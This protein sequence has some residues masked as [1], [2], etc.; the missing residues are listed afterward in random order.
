MLSLSLMM[1]LAAADKPVV[2]V[3]Y[4][5]ARTKDEELV[6]AGK[7][8]A[9]MLTTDLVA[10]EGVRVVERTRLEEV[11]K[12][13]DFQQ[14]KYV[15]KKTAVKIGSALGADYLVVGS[16]QS[17]G[18][19]IRVDAR[20][21]KAK[22]FEDVVSA[23]E[24]DSKDKIFD[25]EQRLANQLVAKI[26]DKLTA[27][28]NARR[29]AKVPDLATVV[30]YGKALDLSDKGQLDEAQAAMRAV[31]SKS[32][33][34][35]LARERQAELLKRFEEYQ[36]RKKDMI[37]GGAIELGKRI[38]A[39]LKDE[40]KFSSLTKEEQEHFLAMRVLKGKFLARVMKQFLSN[41]DSTRVAKKGEE[42]RAL[43]AMR[44]W[45][46]NQRRYMGEFDRSSRQ[47]ATV[48]NGVSY[49]ASMSARLNDDEER[50]V[51][52]SQFGDVNINDFGFENLARFVLE[53]RVDDGEYFYVN[54]VLSA[55]DSKID[56]TVRDEIDARIKDAI[57]RDAAGDKRA[58]NDAT[59]LMEFKAGN[60]VADGDVDR[61]VGA[62]Q[63]MLDSFPTDSRASWVEGR[64]KDLLEGRGNELNDLNRWTEALQ[65]CKDMDIRVG[66]QVLRRRMKQAGL[67]GI[68]DL[69]AELEKK[70]KVSRSNQ[71][72]FAHFYSSLGMEAARADDCD[73]YRA[74]TR[75]YLENDGSVS[76]MLGYNKNYVPWCQLGDV[77]KN[78]TWFHARL[79]GSWSV[80]F[81]RNL[82]SQKSNDKSVFFVR[83]STDGPRVPE[84]VEEEMDLRLE[85]GKDGNYTCV[86]G[87]WRRY[88][89]DYNEGTCKVS[90]TKWAPEDAPGFDEGTFEITMPAA[91]GADG[92]VRKVE[93]TKGEFRTRRER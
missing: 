41:R 24:T 60:Y 52:E 12:E 82:V 45:Y 33:T 37:A 21:V 58:A 3:L 27:N 54:P 68:D 85:R 77:Q 80:E 61:A 42:G 46:E 4:F 43:I 79:D 14:T 67:K 88:W 70:C 6:F 23:S 15:D 57:K 29:K 73:R 72:A 93:I 50:L 38:D 1:L 34:F 65:N 35:L 75:K 26:D 31:I 56:K 91:K 71:N 66:M 25:I 19:K 51:A 2:S 63:E 5:E 92:R 28:S 81:T 62:Y 8:L 7:G 20:L 53:G 83:G 22:T 59:R 89:G 10:W 90:I 48:A 39:T 30:A 74:Y 9:D 76:D 18:D 16:L 11:L 84:G 32:P 47:F 55:V 78:L 49:P 40:P 69:S 64:I 86:L 87:R 13:V 36:K 17:A 44:D